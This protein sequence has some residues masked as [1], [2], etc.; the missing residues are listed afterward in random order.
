MPKDHIST[1]NYIG[2]YKLKTAIKDPFLL[3]N[4]LFYYY[5]TIQFG[6][7]NVKTY[8]ISTMKTG[9]L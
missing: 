1:E 2:D 3:L 9:V 8:E 5:L 4:T 7:M 6:K